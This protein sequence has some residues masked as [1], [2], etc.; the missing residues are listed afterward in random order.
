MKEQRKGTIKTNK[1]VY[2]HKRLSDGEVFYVGIG[3]KKRPYSKNSRN[4]HWR[5]YT[6]KHEYE[7]SIL[8][9]K[10]TWKEACIREKSLI[11][12]YGRRDLGLGT[13]VNMTDGGDGQ[14]NLAQESRSK[15][16]KANKGKVPWMKGRRHTKEAKQA[17]REKHLG[18]I[19][20]NKGLPSPF[21][22]IKRPEHSKLMQ[23]SG[24]SNAKKVIC[25]AT[26]K[27]YKCMLDY[28]NANNVPNYYQFRKLINNNKI[29]VTNE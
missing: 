3:S 13:L 18:N 29:K 10:L 23:G 22:G 26:K 11:L 15:I 16:S 7:V 24:N 1:V 28:I 17:N 14:C 9:E 8:F 21:R 27:E 2:L 19:P 5:N 6:T 20:S 12:D 4:K 25:L